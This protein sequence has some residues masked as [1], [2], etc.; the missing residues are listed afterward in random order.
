MKWSLSGVSRQYQRDCPKSLERGYSV[1][2]W[3]AEKARLAHFALHT[4]AKSTLESLLEPLFGQ[5]L[6][7]LR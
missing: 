6:Y 3:T 1:A 7:E 5:F 2:L 4:L